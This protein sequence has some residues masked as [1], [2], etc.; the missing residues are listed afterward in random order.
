MK[1]RGLS[2]HTAM[3]RWGLATVALGIVIGATGPEAIRLFGSWLAAGSTSLPWVASRLL[4]FLAYVALSGSVVYGLL[5]STKL[6]DAIAH[7]PIS[8]T[9]H[10]DLAAFG[11]A[12]AAIHGALLGL[13][14][15]VP[16]SLAQLV[17]PFATS[18]RPVWVGVGQISLYLMTVVVAS[19]YARQRIGQRTWRLLHY[20]TFLSFAGATMHGLLAGTDAA[21][22][23]HWTYAGST[24]VVIFLSTYRVLLAVGGRNRGGHI[25][26]SNRTASNPRRTAPAES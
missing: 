3:T 5:L 13:D 8:F 20:V 11:L 25:A 2:A 24:A 21:P 17:V 1:F 23:S 15:T 7:R 16:S 14:R 19:F 26:T 9:L 6:L 4:G 10:K 22:W 12:L 18:Y